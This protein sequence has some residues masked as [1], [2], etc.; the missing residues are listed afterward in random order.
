MWRVKKAV[1]GWRE[2]ADSST[3]ESC[4]M[5]TII[6]SLSSAPTQLSSKTAS[7]ALGSREVSGKRRSGSIRYGPLST[8]GSGYTERKI[9]AS[10]KCCVKCQAIT[11]RQDSPR[12]ELSF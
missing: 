1:A 8:S 5:S 2:G 9:V 4:P 6:A 10:L 7:F 3:S 12:N 11:E